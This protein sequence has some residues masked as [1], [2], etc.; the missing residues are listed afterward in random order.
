MFFNSFKSVFKYSCKSH[1][2]KHFLFERPEK[3]E[4]T[5]DPSESDQQD[6]IYRKDQKYPRKPVNAPVV[7]FLGDPQAFTKRA[8]EF[9]SRRPCDCKY[10]KNDE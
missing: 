3:A 6:L 2:A 7:A 8:G 1:S 9:S 10:H 4:L 5:E